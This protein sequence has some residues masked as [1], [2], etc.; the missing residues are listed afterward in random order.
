MTGS[1]ERI[2]PLGPGAGATEGLDEPQSLDGLLATHAGGRPDLAVQVPR[3]RLHVHLEHAL[4]DRLGAHAGGEQAGCTTHA[5]AV[6]AIEFPE[7]PA[8][9]GRLRQQV[10]GLELADLV[11][12]LAD[13]LLEA[14]RLRLEALLLGLELGVQLELQV[15][16]PLLDGCLLG[17]L[18]LLDLR[19]DPFDL[20]LGGLAQGSHGLLV[21]RLSLGHDDLVTEQHG[22]LGLARTQ[23]RDGGLRR[24][25]RLDELGGARP[26]LLL[27]LVLE[28]LETLVQLVRLTMQVGPQLVLALGECLAALASPL[29]LLV[30]LLQEACA[31]IL[32]DPRHEVLGEVEDRLQVAGADVQQDAQPARGAL[33]IPDVAD[34]AGELD[35]TH[36][37]AADLGAGDLHTALVADDALVADALVLA[38]VA[39]PV[40][41]RAK[42]AL[43]EQTVL[44][45]SEGAVVDGLG[46][47]H[48][49]LRPV[50]DLLGAGERDTD[51]VEVVDLEHGPPSCTVEKRHTGAMG[52]PAPAPFRAGR[53]RPAGSVLEPGEID[54]TQVRQRVCRGVLG[55]VDLLLVLVEDLHVEPQRL[56]LLDEHLE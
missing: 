11:L 38:A 41:R 27:A 33:E 47:G 18:P 36:P 19:V 29:G 56:E 8:V 5:A 20:L 42:D 46:L 13:L 49:A 43:V 30:Q 28:R 50:T 17:S 34:G 39:L 45:G 1:T 22:R 3:E 54:A 23:R 40:A 7:V 51:G 35:V 9:E 2:D 55:E 12:G 26:A 52:R 25:L 14:F 6:L 16:D 48:L 15:G 31:R 53:Y 24:L 10:T 4:P 37:L 21:S 44:L 32:V